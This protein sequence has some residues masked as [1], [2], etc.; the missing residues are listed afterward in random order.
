MTGLLDLKLSS[1]EELAEECTR[2]HD[3]PFDLKAQSFDGAEHASRITI[4]NVASAEIQDRAQIGVYTFRQVHRT[5]SGCR[6]EFHQDCDID[7]E[8]NGPFLA[9]LRDV[10]ELTGM[11]GRITSVGFVDFGIAIGPTE[12]SS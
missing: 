1:V 10:R 7:I 9:E 8:V 11:R 6:C 5:A 2:F 3:L 4:R 12:G